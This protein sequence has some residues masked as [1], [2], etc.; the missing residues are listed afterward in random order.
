MAASWVQGAGG[1][2]DVAFQRFVK[3]V[4]LPASTASATNNHGAWGVLL[5]TSAAA[6]LD[7]TRGLD[8]A[9]ARW[10]SLVAGATNEWGYLPQEYTRSGTSNYNGGPDM[11]VKG[12][13][14]THYFM[15]P[16]SIASK[17]LA[18][19]Q[20]W[21]LTTTEGQ[22][23]QLAYNKAALWTR[24]P[25]QFPY[26]ASNKKIGLELEG[27]RSAAYFNLLSRS[28]T[29]GN[30]TAVMNDGN[31]GGNGFKIIELFPTQ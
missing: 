1:W 9:R 23:F 24:Y 26:Y 16:A 28:Y 29:N 20:R 15:L 7:D 22:L 19:Q 6:Y 17:I 25:E 11:G 5:N 14:Y 8:A 3:S 13:A 10:K 31:L 4:V 30:A 27:V 2:K 18:D 21:V 12:I